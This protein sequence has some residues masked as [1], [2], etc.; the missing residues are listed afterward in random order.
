[1]VKRAAFNLSALAE[2]L[3]DDKRFVHHRRLVE[4]YG[5]ACS[6]IR[7]LQNAREATVALSMIQHD[8]T[9]RQVFGPALTMNAVILYCRA[10]ASRTNARRR[11]A[12]EKAMTKEQAQNHAGVCD[13]RSTAMAHYHKV[14]GKY[15]SDW[16][17]DS[18][19]IKEVDRDLRPPTEVFIRRNWTAALMTDLQDPIFLALKTATEEASL[20]RNELFE[21]VAASREQ[22]DLFA[23]RM[24]NFPF[25]HEDFFKGITLDGDFWDDDVEMA[26]ETFSVPEKIVGVDEIMRQ[27]E[28]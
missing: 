15:G 9:F 13:L 6:I 1:M 5:S 16:S 22:D 19:I 26:G 10:T 3:E 11:I 23:R 14:E 27:S 28:L 17:N 8:S 21:L 20:R 12:F 4:Q 2:S 7:D 18:I 25:D 24:E